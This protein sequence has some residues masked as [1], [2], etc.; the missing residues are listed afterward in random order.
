MTSLRSPASTVAWSFAL[1]GFGLATVTHAD[2]DLWGH[3][4][5]GLD[6]LATHSL[7]AT[8]RYSFTQDRAWLN[9]EWLSEVVMAAA[10]EALGTLGLRLLKAAMVICTFA[11]IWRTYRGTAWPA[12]LVAV[13]WLV[14]G[15]VHMIATVRPQ[16]W[17]LLFTVALARQLVAPSRHAY[18]GLPVLFALWANLHGGWIV[19]LGIIGL[20][21]VFGGIVEAG[22]RMQTWAMAGACVL[23]TLATPYGVRLWTFVWE[24]VQFERAITEWRPLWEGASAGEW[25]AWIGTVSLSLWTVRAGRARDLARTAVLLLLAVLAFRVMRIG[26]LFAAVAVVFAST[27]VRRAWPAQEADARP[28]RTTTAA[29]A[30]ALVPLAF[31][32]IASARITTATS[33]I[34]STGPW[35]ADPV[36][37]EVLRSAPPGRLVTAFDWGQYA[38][39]HLGPRIRV[40]VDG[41][42]ETIYSQ[43]HLKRHDEVVMGTDSGLTAL[44]GWQPDYVW[45]PSDARNTRRWLEAH[46]YVIAVDTPRS[47]LAAKTPL[48]AGN[49]PLGGPRCFPD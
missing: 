48:T 44:E 14:F 42:R 43:D 49:P 24:T 7:P 23:A 10:Y 17:S 33:C 25:I 2:P 26:S 18:W 47:F 8:D 41:R 36:A 13:A 31:A 11:L 1:L 16:L 38:I 20:W 12:K 46:G 40:S 4:R 27:W 30:L 19:G 28:R 34:V 35:A 39:W 3:V 6:A 32:A 5:F 9:H 15:A 45:L 37:I 21:V 22:K 29:A